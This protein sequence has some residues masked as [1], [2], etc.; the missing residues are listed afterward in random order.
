MSVCKPLIA[1]S[2]VLS[3]IEESL[4]YQ[5]KP[6]D[7]ILLLLSKK[8][9]HSKVKLSLHNK[10][11]TVKNQVPFKKRFIF[12]KENLDLSEAKI[13]IYVGR[14]EGKDTAIFNEGI[15]NPYS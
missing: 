8:K 10:V 2:S 15:F 14:E 12:K 6:Q 9:L 11:R 7:Q 5:E 1:K 4:Y 13:T 3:S